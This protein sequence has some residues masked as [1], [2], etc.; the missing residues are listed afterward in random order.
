MHYDLFF[1]AIIDT[2]QYCGA[3]HARHF[4][5][6]CWLVVDKSIKEHFAKPRIF[7][8]MQYKG[9]PYLI[10]FLGRAFAMARTS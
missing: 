5:S 1:I 9:M 4:I 6:G 8:R 7:S 3:I 10:N 2:I